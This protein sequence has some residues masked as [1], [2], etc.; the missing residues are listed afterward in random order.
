[1]SLRPIPSS[2]IALG[3]LLLGACNSPT[4]VPNEGSGGASS[5]STTTGTTT[6]SGAG[7]AGGSTAAGGAGGGHAQGGAGGAGGHTAAGGAGGTTGTGGAGGA[8]CVDA[9]SSGA[10]RCVADAMQVCAKGANGCLAWQQ[11]AP[12]PGVETCN[13]TATQ[14]VTPSDVCKTDADCG[15]GCGCVAGGCKC[16]G[17]IPPSCKTDADCGPVC[18]G[19]VCAGGTCQLPPPPGLAD[20]CTKT[21]GTVADGTCCKGTPDFP[22]MC[23]PGPCGCAPQ[24]S[25]PVKICE[26]PAQGCFDPQVGCTKP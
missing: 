22:D 23:A 13:A 24:D 3:V 14:C 5:T 25:N 8:G 19:F 4:V 15:C 11:T 2:I 20:L 7:G 1:M 12:C 21:G 16:T 17:A 18:G 26:C 10:Q 6:S 9:C